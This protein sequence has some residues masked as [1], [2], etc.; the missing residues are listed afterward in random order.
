MKKE[1][2]LIVVFLLLGI[3]IGIQ[4]PLSTVIVKVL[5]KE[6]FTPKLNQSSIILQAHGRLGNVMF[7]YAALYSI[8]CSARRNATMYTKINIISIFPQVTQKIGSDVVLTIETK[9]KLSHSN[10]TTVE[11]M[12]ET[13]DARFHFPFFETLPKHLIQICCYFQD[14]RYFINHIGA[15]R[16]R[17]TFNPVVQWLSKQILR[18]IV[19]RANATVDFNSTIYVGIHVRRSD[20]SVLVHQDQGYRLPEGRYYHKA[21]QYYADKYN[22][23]SFIVASDDIEWCKKHLNIT[24]GPTYYSSAKM[25][26]IDMALMGLC[27]HVIISVG[28]FSWMVGFLSAG[29]V[30]YYRDFARPDSPL[31]KRMPERIEDHFLPSWVPFGD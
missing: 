3:F 11:L 20:L 28:T 6:G 2:F 14:Y 7:Q 25:G 12:K 22:N 4:L 19:E 21:A 10:S 23:V 27:N 18:N 13:S 26:A 30:V 24:V 29:E 17:F 8:A 5:P 1:I 15:I 16:E 31:A 9:K